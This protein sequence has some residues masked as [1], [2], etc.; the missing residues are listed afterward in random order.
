MNV[1]EA[2]EKWGREKGITVTADQQVEEL[3]AD[4]KIAQGMNAA[5]KSDL[6]HCERV[7]TKLQAKNKQLK[8]ALKKYGRCLCG[9]CCRAVLV[10]SKGKGK[11]RYAKE[12][13]CGFEKAL[14]GE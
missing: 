5:L 2:A 9:C 13:D 11:G 10:E 1:K 6:E 7:N 14:K 8:R 3:Q 4:F 12:C